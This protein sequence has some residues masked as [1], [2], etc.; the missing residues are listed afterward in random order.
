MT[1]YAFALHEKL[2]VEDGMDPTSDEYY[3]KLNGR[4][5]QV[6]PEKFA[7][8]E[9]ADAPNSQRPRAS[10]VAPASRSTASRKIVL[11]ST[12]VQLAKKLGVPL[13]LY[14]KKVAEER[15]KNG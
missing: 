6:F 4:I 15:N 1:G 13:E 12:Q 2:V 14:A 3:R 11:N 7:S 9:S 5:R 10:I 8:G